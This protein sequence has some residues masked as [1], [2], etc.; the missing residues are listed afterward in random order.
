MLWAYARKRLDYELNGIMYIL[1]I[2]RVS[3]LPSL[4]QVEEAAT[5]RPDILYFFGQG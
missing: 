5:I 4:E 1:V 2:F 3:P